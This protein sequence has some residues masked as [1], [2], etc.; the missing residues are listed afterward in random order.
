MPDEKHRRNFLLAIHGFQSQTPLS[1]VG[2]E[3]SGGVF[4]WRG[5]RLRPPRPGG[6]DPAVKAAIFHKLSIWIS[7]SIFNKKFSIET[8]FY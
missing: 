2:E 1:Q 7:L 6:P 4:G 5:L 3:V 8:N